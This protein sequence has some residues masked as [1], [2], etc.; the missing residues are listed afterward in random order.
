MPRRLLG[1]L[2]LLLVFV[3]VVQAQGEV[4]LLTVGDEMVSKEEFEYHWGRSSEERAHVYAQT[5]GRFIQKVQWAKE[6]GLDTL[7]T[8]R[9]RVRYYRRILEHRTRMLERRRI[10]RGVEEEWVKLKHVTCPLHQHES[11]R[12]EKEAKAYIDSLY[13][14]L[15]EVLTSHLKLSLGFKHGIC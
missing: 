15:K 7:P 3:S 1:V 2:I 8:Y 13:V 10:H 14:S 4:A 6:L 11:R 12:K 5:Y 9:E